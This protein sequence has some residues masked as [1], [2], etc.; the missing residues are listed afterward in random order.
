MTHD[1][2]GPGCPLPNRDYSRIV[3]GHGGGG[4]LS[5]ELIETVFLPEFENAE[6][7]ELAD[8]AVVELESGSVAVTTDSYVVRPLFFP[9]G[10]IGDLAIN[11]TVNDL[12]MRGANPRV[13]TAGFIIEEGLELD[14]LRQIVRDMA[15]SARSAGVRV[16]AGDTKV[17][18][19]GSCDGCYVNTAG[20]GVVPSGVAIGPGRARAGDVVL[21]SGS[22][23]DHAMAIMS[24]RESL[25]FDAEIRSDTAP[26]NGLVAT[27]LEVCPEIHVLRDP[28]RGGLAATLNEIA[29]ASRVGIVIRQADVPVRPVVASACEI[30]GFDPLEMANEGKLVCVAPPQY[31]DALVQAMRSHELGRESILIGAIVE[32]HPR[33]VVVESPM[34]SKRI[35]PMPLGEPLPR[36]C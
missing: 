8:S 3:L 31:A 32:D 7:A 6:L 12:A 1:P 9:G 14:R 28:T 29:T 35:L 13:L 4:Q 5:K 33:S 34:G 23:A 27:M 36:I 24:V 21:I 25:G 18:E 19:R 2:D 11:G 20:F 22:I 15:R 17:V 10:S 26:L 30:L 16:V